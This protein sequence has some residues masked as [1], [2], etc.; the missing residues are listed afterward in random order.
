MLSASLPLTR[1]SKTS[2]RCFH[3]FRIDPAT[4][5]ICMV[6]PVR[7]LKIEDMACLMCNHPE[8]INCN[9]VIIYMLKD[10]T[11]ALTRL[12]TC[13]RLESDYPEALLLCAP[14]NRIFRV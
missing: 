8:T 1:D 14:L 10:D 11:T 7:V 3:F 12:P 5:A 13:S 4:G 6:V 2:A 9:F